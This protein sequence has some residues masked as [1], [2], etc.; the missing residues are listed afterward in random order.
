MSVNLK[1]FRGDSFTVS[2]AMLTTGNT[3]FDL[4]GQSAKVSFRWPQCQTVTLTSSGG[5]LT[6][7]STAGTIQGMF[8]EE[9]TR[10]LPDNV[11]YYVVLET[12]LG[13]KQTHYLGRVKVMSCNSSVETCSL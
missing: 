11:E 10:C 9:D 5:D 1:L 13:V 3:V 8:D 6:I 12:T 4:T 7:D 2:L